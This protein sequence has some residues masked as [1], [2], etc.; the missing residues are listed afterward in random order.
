VREDFLAHQQIAAALA[1]SLNESSLG[2]RCFSDDVAVRALSGLPPERFLRSAFVPSVA[3][4]N[5]DDFLAW[6][7]KQNAA[8]L[9]FFPTEDSLPAK[10]FPEL[11]RKDQESSNNF[12]L[13]SFA[14]SSFGP[15][16]WLYRLR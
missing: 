2:A 7:R 6:L 13:V 14:R 9:V 16:I 3:T 4:G 12:K 5:G 15:D 10:F 1:R 8:Y 11:S